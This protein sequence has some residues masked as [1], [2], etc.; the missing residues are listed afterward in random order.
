MD[1]KWRLLFSGLAGA[2]I[3]LA[4]TALQ[5]AWADDA[6]TVGT[7]AYAGVL[8]VEGKPFDGKRPLGL[9]LHETA[10]SAKRLCEAPSKEYDLVAGRFRIDL[11]EDCVEV[12]RSHPNAWFALSVAGTQLA[13]VRIHA[14]PYALRAQYAAS[15]DRSDRD[16]QVGNDA[17]VAG[18]TRVTGDLDVGGTAIRTI[19]RAHA[20]G[21][22]VA[23]DN[24]AVDKRTLSFIKRRDDTSI[25]VAYTDNFRANH[26]SGIGTCRWAIMFDNQPCPQA[27]RLIY[28][29]FVGGVPGMNF[30]HPASVFGTCRGLPKGEHTIQVFVGPVESTEPERQQANCHT[31]WGDQYWSLEAEE[32]L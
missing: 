18:S 5:H 21:P 25:R 19:R 9:T 3:A 15:A 20:L 8:S 24:G 13:P 2:T 27:P 16:F 4:G 11:P 7:L 14:V 12:V 31:G 23:Q 32:V 22:S 1:T 6:S 17:V 26:P 30:H 29:L 28:D 10:T